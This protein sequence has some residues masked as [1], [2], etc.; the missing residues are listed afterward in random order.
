MSRWQSGLG[1]ATVGESQSE[2]C[3]HPRPLQYVPTTGAVIE[4]HS[5][6][7]QLYG[8]YLRIHAHFTGLR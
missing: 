7:I 1:Q 3:S 6:R 8:A 5:K 4:I 2:H